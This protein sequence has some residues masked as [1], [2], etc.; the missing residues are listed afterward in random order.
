MGVPMPAA[1]RKG[2]QYEDARAQYAGSPATVPAPPPYPAPGLNARPA[3][4]GV[5]SP[6]NGQ[7]RAP[8]AASPPARAPVR[9][10]VQRA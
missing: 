4:P 10:R 8:R 3:Q 5:V 6:Q 9:S 1:G 7:A 2:P